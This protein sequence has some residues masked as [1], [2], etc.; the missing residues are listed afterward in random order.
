[1]KWLCLWILTG[2]WLCIFVQEW[3]AIDWNLLHLT[4]PV[5]MWQTARQRASLPWIM[6]LILSVQSYWRMKMFYTC[7]VVHPPTGSSPPSSTDWIVTAALVPPDIAS[8][9]APFESTGG[10]S[11]RWPTSGFNLWCGFLLLLKRHLAVTGTVPWWTKCGSYCRTFSCTAGTK[12]AGGKFNCVVWVATIDNCWFVVESEDVVK[13]VDR[14]GIRV[15]W[16]S[17]AKYQ[18]DQGSKPTWT[19]NILTRWLKRRVG[20][21]DPRD[22]VRATTSFSIR[23][24]GCLS[25]VADAVV[26]GSS[27]EGRS[28]AGSCSNSFATWARGVALGPGPPFLPLTLIGI[29]TGECQLK[30]SKIQ[31]FKFRNEMKI[32]IKVHLGIQLSCNPQPL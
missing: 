27:R 18:S 12:P 25:W 22:S 30:C 16:E 1:M 13:E 7:E 11:C 15:S 32:R 23:A 20:G 2:V 14:T 29:Y 31:K 10:Q 21:S 3:G 9:W 17:I 4:T 8:C 26:V 19:G 6:S 28:C 24:W 5:A